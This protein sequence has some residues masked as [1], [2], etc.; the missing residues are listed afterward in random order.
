MTR[1]TEAALHP[2][3]LPETVPIPATFPGPRTAVHG[4]RG[5]AGCP[6]MVAAEAR[7]RIGALSSMSIHMVC[8]CKSTHGPYM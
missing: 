4:L 2:V 7:R 5:R 6:A 3:S 1:A 8:T